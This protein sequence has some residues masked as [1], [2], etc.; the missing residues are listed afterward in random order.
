MG[1][2]RL[3]GAG[4]QLQV[5]HRGLGVPGLCQTGF[6]WAETGRP[7]SPAGE[8]FKAASGASPGD[9]CI[10]RVSWLYLDQVTSLPP[11]RPLPHLWPDIT[12]G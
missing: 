1:D 8:T 11:P 2:R 12:D 9:Q 7:R 10:D 4:S 3:A 5:R 6:W